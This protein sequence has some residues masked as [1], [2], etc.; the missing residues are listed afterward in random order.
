MGTP[1]NTYTPLAS[2]CVV[3]FTCVA[4]WVRTT[5]ALGTTAPVASETVPWM[6]PVPAICARTSEG[7]SRSMKTLAQPASRRSLD[8]IVCI[9]SST[10]KCW[11]R[12]AVRFGQKPVAVRFRKIL[13]FVV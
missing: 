3:R 11:A 4:C 12:P 13:P 5:V 6:L 2:L 1:G 8:P 9:N 7:A 10:F